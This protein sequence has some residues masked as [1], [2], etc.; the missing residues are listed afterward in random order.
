LNRV[1][2][3]IKGG[4]SKTLQPNAAALDRRQTH[5]RATQQLLEGRKSERGTKKEERIKKM[6]RERESERD[7][8][9][10]EETQLVN[11]ARHA[12]TKPNRDGL[13]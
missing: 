9:K 4:G 12:S 5:K 6:G 1:H 8:Q 3:I 7:R 10:E 13:R 2:F 11:G